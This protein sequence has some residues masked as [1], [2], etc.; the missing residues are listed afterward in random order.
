MNTRRLGVFAPVALSLCSIVKRSPGIHFRGLGRAANVSSAGQLR[1]HIDRLERHGALIEVEDG[2]FKRFFVPDAYDT[3]IREGLA[4]FSR[5]V[6]HLIGKL[7]V[8]QTLNRTELRRK[9]GC[10]DSTLGYHLTRMISMGDVVRVPGRN[11]CLYSLADREF[12]RQLLLRKEAAQSLGAEPLK[13]ASPPAAGT[14]DAGTHRGPATPEPRDGV[15]PNEPPGA[16]KPPS[17]AVPLLPMGD[18]S[19]AAPVAA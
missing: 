4:R 2:R 16:P 14:G 11:C 13:A 6:P 3:R 8:D 12:V 17:P 15:A 1:H 19:P 18:P 10:A 9:L 5:R 7:L